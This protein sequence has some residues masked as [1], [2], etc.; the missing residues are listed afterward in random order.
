MFLAT[1]VVLIPSA[2]SRCR[3]LRLEDLADIHLGDAE[4]AVRV[5]LDLV[6]PGEILGATSRTRPSAITATPSRR[7]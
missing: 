4:V 1:I 6:Q 7:P 5:V 3:D 2:L